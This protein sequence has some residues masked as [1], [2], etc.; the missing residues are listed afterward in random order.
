MRLPHGRHESQNLP[1]HD[2]CRGA[3][4]AVHRGGTAGREGLQ[5]RPLPSWFDHVPDLAAEGPYVMPDQAPLAGLVLPAE[6]HQLVVEDDTALLAVQ[7]V[8]GVE[9]DRDL[10]VDLADLVLHEGVEGGRRP[11]RLRDVDLAVAL[12]GFGLAEADNLGALEVVVVLIHQLVDDRLDLGHPAPLD[13]DE[14]LLLS[15]AFHPGL[16]FRRTIARSA[17]R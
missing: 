15:M 12:A 5:G 13:L 14:F 11:A 1:Y 9:A 2:R 17:W 7:L 8:P 10:V 4:R 6:A 16:S 3:R